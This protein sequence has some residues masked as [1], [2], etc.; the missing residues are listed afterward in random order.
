MSIHN[1][2][3]IFQHRKKIF[4]RSVI[5]YAFFLNLTN[6]IFEWFL[7]ILLMYVFHFYDI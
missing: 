5:L 2:L 7:S 4:H 6:S 1:F 3:M